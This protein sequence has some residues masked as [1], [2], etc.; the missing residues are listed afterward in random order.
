ML[1]LHEERAST[2]QVWG[3]A[4][5]IYFGDLLT[6]S[7]KYYGAGRTLFLR[8]LLYPTRWAMAAVQRLRRINQ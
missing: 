7:H 4:S 6:F 3:L 8:A 5:R 2:K 1:L